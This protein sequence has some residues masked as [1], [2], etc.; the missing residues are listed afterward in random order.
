MLTH[1][2]SPTHAAPSTQ[3]THPSRAPRDREGIPSE[4]PPIGP[5]ESLVAPQGRWRGILGVRVQR[6]YVCCTSS[7]DMRHFFRVFSHIDSSTC[8]RAAVARQETKKTTKATAGE[9]SGTTTR[10]N[11]T[12]RNTVTTGNKR[13]QHAPWVISAGKTLPQLSRLPHSSGGGPRGTA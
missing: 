5:V 12:H 6:I 11:L 3:A 9:T 1:T 7:S 13:Q 4:V 8:T 10:P 2:P